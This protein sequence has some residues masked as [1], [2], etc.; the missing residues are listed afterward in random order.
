MSGLHERYLLDLDVASSCFLH[1][2]FIITA[3]YCSEECR[4]I[5]LQK[6]H[7][8]DCSR[9]TKIH[10]ITKDKSMSMLCEMLYHF[11]WDVNAMKDFFNSHQRHKTIFD[12]DMSDQSDYH[13]NLLFAMMKQKPGVITDTCEECQA[14][15]KRFIQK[16]PK[17]RS[18]FASHRNENFLLGLLQKLHIVTFED[19]YSNPFMTNI[20]MTVKDE[21]EFCLPLRTKIPGT[22]TNIFSYTVDPYRTQLQHSC[23]SSI[24]ILSYN[25]KLAWIVMCPLSAGDQ[26]CVNRLPPRL[27]LEARQE[28]QKYIMDR[29]GHKCECD[30]CKFDWKIFEDKSEIDRLNFVTYSRIYEYANFRDTKE[31][32]PEFALE[33]SEAIT[34]VSKHL[35][36]LE[37]W[38]C[39]LALFRAFMYSKMPRL[40]EK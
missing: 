37:F 23:S 4:A 39:K 25:G 8:F 6:F 11:D 15:E 32:H 33:V 40:F 18:I 30:A 36:N 38:V 29:F 21:D 2:F 13:K 26:L 17:L 34:I 10:C 27:Q 28:R 3:M 20:D 5:D 12:F 24:A 9:R 35:P 14:D 31:N 22:F 1:F 19:L 16:H 7:Q